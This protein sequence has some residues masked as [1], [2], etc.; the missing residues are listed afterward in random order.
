MTFLKRLRVLTAV[1]GVAALVTA[2]VAHLL[3]DNPK[4]AADANGRPDASRVVEDLALTKFSTLRSAL[5]VPLQGL[6]GNIGVLA[7]YRAEKDAFSREDLR[8][9][10]AAFAEAQARIG[11]DSL[12]VD[13]RKRGAMGGRF[14]L[15]SHRANQVLERRQLRP[16]LRRASHMIQD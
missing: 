13:S 10:L 3:G 15:R 16:G 7:I 2:T 8:I 11:H 1:L 5:A 4:T 12:A 9:L 14:E 6:N